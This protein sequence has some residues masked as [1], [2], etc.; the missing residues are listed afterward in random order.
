MV[1]MPKLVDHDERRTDFA[2][3]AVET[4]ARV[5]LDQVRLVDVGHVA[6]T[7][8]GAIG[9]YFRSRDDLLVAAFDL[10]ADELLAS[11]LGGT[12]LLEERH[13]V[14]MLPTT[15]TKAARWAVWL[16]FC[17]RVGFDGDLKAVYDRYYEVVESGVTDRLGVPDA[18]AATAYSGAL[19]AA[20]DGVGLCATVQPQRWPKARQTE[21]LLQLIGPVFQEIHRYRSASDNP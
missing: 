18:V 19:V 12:R 11:L 9:H 15:R 7:T 6:G 16:A 2:R 4:I 21:A 13:F 10:T 14:Q 3:A 17:G 20:V 5:G 8:T 1:M